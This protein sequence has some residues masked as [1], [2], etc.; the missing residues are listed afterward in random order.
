VIGDL[1]FCIGDD[2]RLPTYFSL[3]LNRD[4][5]G[6]GLATEACSAALE[7]FFGGVG[8]RR[9]VACCSVR[10]GPACHLLARLGFRKEGEFLKERLVKGE[11]ITTVSFAMLAEEYEGRK[12][13]SESAPPK[14]V[15]PAGVRAAPRVPGAPSSRA[16]DGVPRRRNEPGPKR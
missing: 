2:N 9:V 14:S 3:R 1:E 12:R 5:H 15:P 10:N 4:H 8:V 13:G 11:W 16:E 7:F 6:H